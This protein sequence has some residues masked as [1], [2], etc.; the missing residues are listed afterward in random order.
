MKL[1][2]Y[3]YFGVYLA[4]KS[5]SLIKIKRIMKRDPEEGK[6][7]AFKKV[8]E[9]TNY[10]MKLSRTKLEVYGVENIPEEACVFVSNHQAIFDA[11][12]ILCPLKNVT[13]FIAKKEIKKIP[14]IHAWLDAIGTVFI[15]RSNIREG[16][17]ALTEGAQN[18][19]K[20]I[21]MVI[22]PE[23]TR[24]LSSEMGTMKKGSLK[25]AFMAKAPIVP[26]T[27]DGTYRVLEVGNKVTGHTI[28]IMFHKPIYTTDLSK[29]EQKDLTDVIQDTIAS[30][31]K[32][33]SES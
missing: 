5:L 32:H 30:G 12:A 19:K 26:V 3:S 27:V 18:I 2:W 20:G 22:F 17:K 21:S 24:S 1:L 11:F 28:K 14:L 7:Y 10:V 6:K 4:G 13:A 25:M 31:L 15:D 8:Q 33:L 29:E 9:I 23:G 16:M